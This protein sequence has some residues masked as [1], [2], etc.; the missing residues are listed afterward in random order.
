MVDFAIVVLGGVVAL[1]G[2]SIQETIKSRRR[3]TSLKAALACEIASLVL[4]IR[5][6]EYATELRSHAASIRAG[7]Q[8]FRYPTLFIPIGQSYFSVFEGNA[9]LIGELKTDQVV[10]IVSFYQQARSL[11]DSLSRPGTPDNTITP[12]AEA[13]TRYERLAEAIDKLCSLGDRVSDSMAPRGV[14]DQIASVA[15][16]LRPAE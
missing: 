7:G 6:Q 1:G 16:S 4:L 5:H 14:A 3:R 9:N 10:Q 8:Q 13:A 15:K 2:W 11:T 12:V